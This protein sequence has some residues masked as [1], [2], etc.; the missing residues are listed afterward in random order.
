MT[1]SGFMSI[2]GAMYFASAPLLL[3][4]ST[5]IGSAYSMIVANTAKLTGSSLIMVNYD[6]NVLPP[7]LGGGASQPSG[8]VE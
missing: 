6:P 2:S 7:I 4:G 1:G 8:L 3:T 5:S